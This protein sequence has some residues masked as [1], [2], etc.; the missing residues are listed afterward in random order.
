M[1]FTQGIL[2]SNPIYD[3]LTNYIEE[4]YPNACILYIDEIHNKVLRDSYEYRK[5]YLE[6]KRGEDNVQEKQL[7]HG[8]K[9]ESIDN[10]IK[11]GFKTEYNKV[12]AFGKG[13][14]FSTAANYSSVYADL[15]GN[16]V[17]YMFVCD[18]LIGKAIV[19]T[20]NKVMD[21]EIC[22]NFVNKMTEPT[23]YVTPY[24]N[25]AYPKYLIAFYKNAY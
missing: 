12:S 9:T 14:Y 24:D 2:M 11:H 6:M 5:I 21:T 20:Q 8:T 17:S 15:D 1:S 18:V 3:D 13:T 10:I 23:I 7:F 22:D 19:G 4:S 25:G 16:K